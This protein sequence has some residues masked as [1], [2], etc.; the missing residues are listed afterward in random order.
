MRQG[1]QDWCTGM[2]QMYEEEEER[3]KLERQAE[4]QSWRSLDIM[5][6]KMDLILSTK[7]VL[8]GFLSKINKIIF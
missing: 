4:V 8:K 5:L 3:M 2:T 1:A 7:Q 6:W